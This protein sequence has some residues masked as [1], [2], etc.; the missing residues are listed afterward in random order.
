VAQNAAA[1]GRDAL[2]KPNV[3][4]ILMTAHDDLPVVATAMRE[5]AT[6]YLI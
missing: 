3:D 5:G 1:A 4:G 2:P 6:D